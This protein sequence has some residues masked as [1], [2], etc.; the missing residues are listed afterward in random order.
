MKLRETPGE[1]E[2]EDEQ[3]EMLEYKDRL[4]GY[5]IRMTIRNS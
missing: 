1:N 4:L 2:N 5:Y 3:K